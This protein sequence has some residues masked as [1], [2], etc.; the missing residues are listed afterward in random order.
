MLNHII[1]LS[2]LSDLV[3]AASPFT[4]SKQLSRNYFN[5]RTHTHLFLKVFS[6][7]WIFLNRIRQV[8]PVSLPAQKALPLPVKFLFAS[9]ANKTFFF[10][11]KL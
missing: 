5:P 9:L 2:L 3:A 1:K 8:A 7:W 6:P 10:P 11:P 4:C